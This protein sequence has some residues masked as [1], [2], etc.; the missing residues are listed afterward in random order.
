MNRIPRGIILFA[1]VVIFFAGCNSSSPPPITLSVTPASALVFST[2]S[3]QLTAADSAGP[4]DV[5]WSVPAGSGAMVDSTG[6]FTAPTVTQN[7]SI[8]VT[9][10]SVK[11]PT[12]TST[13]AIT[14]LASG[15]VTATANPQVAM[16]T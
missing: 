13:A 10:S 5:A 7:T 14:V 6:N 15:Q 11:D 4:T 12:K 8:M 3:I 16:Y 2:Q 1:A 9:A